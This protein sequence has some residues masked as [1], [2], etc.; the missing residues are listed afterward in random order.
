MNGILNIILNNFIYPYKTNER[1]VTH[2]K[3]PRILSCDAEQVYSAITSRES[4]TGDDSCH[5]NEPDHQP[6][7]L[8]W[9]KMMRTR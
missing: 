3:Q 6:E 2:D 7:R 8:T 9:T 4:F 1:H 5:N